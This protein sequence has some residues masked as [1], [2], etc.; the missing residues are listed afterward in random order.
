MTTTDTAPLLRDLVEIPTSVQRSDFVVSLAQGIDDAERTVGTY[1]VTEQLVTAFDQ[2]LSLVASAIGDRRSK[3]AYLHG[4]FGSGKSHFM[5]VLHLLLQQH[6][7]ARAVPELAPVV[8]KTDAQ[9]GGECSAAT[10]TTSPASIPKRACRRC[11][12]TTSSSP[13]R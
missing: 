12:P 1:V 3:G 2:A 6:P 11:S 10:S 5:A 8:A 4:S 7:A 9:L 13:T